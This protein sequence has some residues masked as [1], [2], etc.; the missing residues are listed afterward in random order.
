MH[1]EGGEENMNAKTK[2]LGVLIAA[3][4]LVSILWLQMGNNENIS[5]K[6]NNGSK[7]RIGYYEGGPYINYVRHLKAVV[8]GLSELGWIKPIAVPEFED[9][10]NSNL[11]WQHLAENVES[12]YVEFVDDA[13]W[14]AD[15]NSTLRE[16]NREDAINHLAEG[17]VVDLML[18]MGTWAGID[19]ATEEHSVPTIVMSASDPVSSGIVVSAEDSGLNHVHAKCEPDQYLDQVRLFHDIVGFQRLGVVYEPTPEGR[20]YA[21]LNDLAQVASERGFEMLER[22]VPDADVSLEEARAGVYEAY[23]DLAPQIDALWIGPHRGESLEYMPELLEPLF[24]Y[25]VATWTSEGSEPVKRGV[26][27]SISR[28]DYNPV[29]LWTAKVIAQIL[30]GAKP[31][32]LNQIFEPPKKIAINMETA[33]RIGYEFPENIL[34]IADEIY[35]TIETG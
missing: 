27:L 29:G 33:R 2:L 20:V 24:E 30:N 12:D 18:A 11:I 26:L 34:S 32:S 14:S 4:I 17:N 21:S 31:R 28:I 6:T 22:R 3:T 25:N 1:I 10:E 16:R 23:Q 19:L 15:W 35:E 9:S 5:P 8:N 13:Y 7:W